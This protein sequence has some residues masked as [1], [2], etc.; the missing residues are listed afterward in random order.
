MK[1][2]L[3]FLLLLLLPLLAVGQRTINYRG[4]AYTINTKRGTA[5]M[6]GYATNIV[7]VN[8]IDVTVNIPSYIIYGKRKYKVTSI[9]DNAFDYKDC[10]GQ[11]YP[12]SVV[13]PNTVTKI[14]DYAFAYCDGLTSIDIPNSVTSIGDHAFCWCHYLEDIN[15][16]GSVKS[17]GE[18]AFSCCTQLTT[19]HIPASVTSI[20]GN[21]FSEALETITVDEN[22]TIYNSANNCNAIIETATNKLIA[23]C[24]NT[25]IP[26]TVTKIGD[27]AFSGCTGL[28]S[29]SI[30]NSVTSIGDA[31][32][33]GCDGLTSITLPDAVTSIGNNAFDGCRNLTS[34]T[35]PNSVTSIG[36]HAFSGCSELTDIYVKRTNPAGYK[37]QRSNYDG[38]Y[39]TFEYVPEDCTLHVPA[40]CASKY[41]RTAPW[42]R[43]YNIVE[44]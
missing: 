38:E 30:P 16:P 43:F 5:S 22:N 35:I 20:E 39:H 4:L 33:N 21:P 18:S 2:L 13:I 36:D 9:G 29:I 32:F 15:I 8:D 11:A 12:E 7:Y 23:G 34:I 28:T 1:R 6:A 41:R 24:Q 42:S 17:I 14:G 25:V 26:N 3:L 19:I 31:A 40:G 27:Y 37:C 10:G 44:Y